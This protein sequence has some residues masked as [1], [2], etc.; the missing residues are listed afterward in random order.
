MAGVGR[1]ENNSVRPPG[2]HRQ[3]Y[4]K[5]HD[6][7]IRANS[8]LHLVWRWT[9]VTSSRL[10]QLGA[11]LRLIEPLPALPHPSSGNCRTVPPATP[12]GRANLRC[13]RLPR[14]RRFVAGKVGSFVPNVFE[15][16]QPTEFSPTQCSASSLAPPLLAIAAAPANVLVA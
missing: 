2:T 6:G 1:G 9:S 7:E 3:R 11:S 15:Q 10:H 16:L 13:P 12:A 8:V 4:I 14:R 5:W